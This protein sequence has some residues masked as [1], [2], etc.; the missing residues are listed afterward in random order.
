M[1]T[2]P[3]VRPDATV[4]F[5]HHSDAFNLNE[6]A[7][8]A[9][10]RQ[11]CPVAWNEN[12]DGFWYLSSY[13]AVS[14]TARDGDT[15]AHK[16]EPNAPDG[17]DYQGEMG[18]PRPDGQPALG[19]GE[20]DGPYHQALRH[21]LAPFFSPGAVEK[22]KP[23]MEQSA[24][25]FLDQHIT[26]GQMDLVLDYASPVPAILTM[27][28]MG[29]PYD[30]WHLYANLFHSVMAV[31]Q[32]SDEYADAIAKVPAMMQEVIEFATAR[33][34]NPEDDLTSFLL[35]FE[36][37]GHRLTDEQL[38]NILWNLIGGGVDTTTS[39]TALTLRHLGTHPDLRQQLIDHPELYRTATDEFL[40]YFSVN[41]TLSRTVTH[42]VVLGGQC[43]RKNDRVVL[44]WLSANHDETEFDR[45]DEIILDRAPNRHVAFG[46][47]PH[48]C[49]GSHLARLMSAVMVKAVLDRIPDYEVDVENVHQ[50]LGNPSMTGLGK[51]PVTFTPRPSRETERPW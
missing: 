19:I 36:F 49:I 13:E 21:A 37:D 6:L 47:G 42:D 48:R 39:Q 23:F 33:R 17:V 7:V 12:Y 29:L 24:H 8:N 30:N 4:D 51:L 25:W 28:L 16:Y 34:S 38:L 31:P 11:R 40:R 35:Q 14:H 9:E 5:D 46:L 1:V 3:K 32:D 41:Q 2:R 20:V 22:L 15:F 26:T 45:P 10:L 43:L 27:K 50:Y 18:V 44:S